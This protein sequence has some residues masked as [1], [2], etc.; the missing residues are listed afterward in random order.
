M[1]NLQKIG[2]DNM[3]NAGQSGTLGYVGLSNCPKISNITMIC[4][5]NAYEINFL[6]NA[7]LDLGKL[8]S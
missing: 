6:D 8:N 3:L 5:S 7:I 4:T 1:P 2:F